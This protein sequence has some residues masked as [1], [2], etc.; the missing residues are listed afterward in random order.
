MIRVQNGN[1][2]KTVKTFLKRSVK[3]LKYMA[4]FIWNIHK[5]INNTC[6]RCSAQ[7]MT[8]RNALQID[9]TIPSKVH[10]KLKWNTRQNWNPNNWKKKSFFWVD[11]F[12]LYFHNK[13]TQN[14]LVKNSFCVSFSINV[15]GFQFYVWLKYA[16]SF[17]FSSMYFNFFVSVR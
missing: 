7:I 15:V 5:R 9:R 14:F 4:N 1:Y 12:S 10:I 17:I 3:H 8:N 6:T 13:Y 2:V 16:V 11:F